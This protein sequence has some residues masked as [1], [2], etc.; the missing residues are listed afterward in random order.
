MPNKMLTYCLIATLGL[1][2]ASVQSAQENENQRRKKAQRERIQDES[3]LSRDQRIGRAI[4]GERLIGRQ[5]HSQDGENLGRLRDV[6]VEFQS[7]RIVYAVLDK[8]G[9]GRENRVAVPPN[10]LGYRSGRDVDDDDN[11][12]NRENQGRALVFKGDAK[13]LE[14]APAFAEDQAENLGNHQYA[15]QAY[16]H[17]GLQP[18]WDASSGGKFG[19]LQRLNKVSSQQVNNVQN[20]RLGKV[21]DLVLDLPAAR[22]L[23]VM[24]SPAKDASKQD[25]YLLVPPMALTPSP[26]RAGFVL[27]ATTERLR[28]APRFAGS[29]RQRLADPE[30]AKKVYE[31]Y[32]KQPYFGTET[33][34]PTGPDK[35]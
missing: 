6:V 15:V 27:S 25:E 17:F 28:E 2:V 24:V 35:D 32:G 23:Y 10:L 20:E 26:D 29:D 14:N 33:L 3:S 21:H 30:F 22:V 12:R 34:T 7:G 19:D 31:F 18:W 13:K 5:V 1:S 8:R 16:K 9:E 4:P 11:N